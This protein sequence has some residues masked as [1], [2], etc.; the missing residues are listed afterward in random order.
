MEIQFFMFDLPKDQSWSF[1]ECSVKDTSYITHNY[2]T[3]P[4]KFIPQLASR[5]LMDY[6]EKGD[7]VIDPFMGSGTTI[8]ES[9]VQ[10][11][12]GIGTDINEIAHLVAK[13]KTTPIKPNELL[14]EFL[15]LEADLKSRTNG[16]KDYFLEKA[17]TKLNFHERV[18]YWYKPIQKEN[19]AVLLCRIL[20][21]E[22]EN[23]KNFFLV[24]FAQILKTC[25]IWLQKSIKPTRDLHKKEYDVLTTFLQQSKKMLKKND[26]FYKLLSQNTIE[27][28]DNQRI[29][30]LCLH[31][32][33]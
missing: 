16:K 32:H 15:S 20:E 1:T 27:N 29:V 26:A 24:A 21:I 11:R 18:D 3:Y 4:A 19:L 17:L 23:C 14:Q 22:H 12:I 9:L 31:Q 13:V 25:S 33:L 8:V 7:I 28:I 6:S 10:G 5:L 30:V 2:Y